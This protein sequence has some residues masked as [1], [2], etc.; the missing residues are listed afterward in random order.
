[1]TSKCSQWLDQALITGFQPNFDPTAII[2]LQRLFDHP[3][4]SLT[5]KIV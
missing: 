3:T 1:M 5:K 4:A 2:D